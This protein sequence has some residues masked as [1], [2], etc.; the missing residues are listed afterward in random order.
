MKKY[1]QNHYMNITG[2]AIRIENAHGGVE[3]GLNYIAGRV[4][5]LHNNRWG[6]VCKDEDFNHEDTLDLCRTGSF[7]G[8]F[9]S[10]SLQ[11]IHIVR[12]IDFSE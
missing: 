12:R 11:N 3:N 6:S 8:G 9:V 1:Y 10:E 2:N 4:L 5:V 7:K